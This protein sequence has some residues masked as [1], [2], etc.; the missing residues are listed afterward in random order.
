MTIAHY[1]RENDLSIWDV[2]LHEHK[3]Y[4]LKTIIQAINL[5]DETHTFLLPFGNEEK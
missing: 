3:W 4:Y 5:A 2:T 1:V